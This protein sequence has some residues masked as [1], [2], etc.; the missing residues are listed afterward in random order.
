[1]S[2][3]TVSGTSRTPRVVFDHIVAYFKAQDNLDMVG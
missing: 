3:R 1:M 2:R